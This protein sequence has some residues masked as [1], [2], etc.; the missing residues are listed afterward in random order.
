MVNGAF[1]MGCFMVIIL[2]CS[3]EKAYKM[4]KPY[5]AFFKAYRDASRGN[6]L[7]NCTLLHCLQGLEYAIMF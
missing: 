5:H 2:K 4:F 6:C 3:A 7:Y 1:L